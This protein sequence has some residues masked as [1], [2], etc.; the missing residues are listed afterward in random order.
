MPSPV[1]HFLGGVAAGW[2]VMP[3]ASSPERGLRASSLV[4]DKYTPLLFGI[5]GIAPDLDILFRMHR[6]VT[7]SVGGAVVV[8]VIALAVLGVRQARLAAALAAAIVSHFLLDWFSYDSNKPTGVMMLWPFYRHYFEP[9]YP[10][11]L[12]I[13]KQFWTAA[14][15]TQNA[16]AVVREVLILGPVV[17]LIAWMRSRGPAAA[18]RVPD[19]RLVEEP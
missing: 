16:L 2:L 12:S 11:F 17:G 14:F 9:P 15:Y 1:G 19:T 8:F 10:L 4:R 7:H 13:S 5:V 18:S 3:A 6:T